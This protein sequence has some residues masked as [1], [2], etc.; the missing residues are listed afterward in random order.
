MATNPITSDSL[1]L[2]FKQL[3][4]IPIGNRVQLA[5]SSSSFL[6]L[7][8]NSLTPIQIAKAFPDYYKRALPDISNFILANRY[9]DAG[10]Q[11]HQTGGGEAGYTSEYYN[12]GNNV[13]GSA[14]PAGSELSIEKMKQKLLEKGIDVEGA[15]SLLNEGPILA[16]DPR[17][18][19]IKNMTNDQLLAAGIQKVEDENGKSMFQL[20]PSKYDNMTD[21]EIMEYAKKTAS[22]E[23]LQPDSKGYVDQDQLFKVLVNRFN[24]SNLNGFVPIDGKAFG[25]E[26]GTPEE[27]ARLALALGKQESSLHA[28]PGGGYRGGMYQFREDDLKRYGVT[29]DV[30]DPNVQVEA[31]AR[32]F[33]KFIPKSGAIAGRG[34]GPGTYGGYRGGAAYFEPLRYPDQLSKHWNS[35]N[36][37]FE[38]YKENPL[39][40]TA[41]EDPNEVKIRLKELEKQ[42]F[43][44][45]LVKQSYMQASP[46][47]SDFKVSNAE[48]VIRSDGSTLGPDARQA[49]RQQ[50]GITI[51]LDNNAGATERDT[52]AFNPMIV[53]PDDATDQ[54]RAAATEYVNRIADAYNKKFGTNL[55]GIV[56]SRSE[57]R[58]GRS[59]TI[60]TEAFNIRDKDA[61]DYFYNTEEGQAEL[62]NITASTLGQIPGANFQLPHGGLEGKDKGA[63]GPFGSE[64]DL[65]SKL[66]A[67]LSR[68]QEEAKNKNTAPPAVADNSLVKSDEEK[69]LLENKKQ[70][71]VEAVPVDNLKKEQ[72]TAKK[73][74]E[75]KVASATNNPTPQFALGGN[76]YGLN[77]DMTLVETETGKPIAQ[78]GQN[79]KIEKQGN[80][81]QVTP[82]TKL[83]ADEL[84]EKYDTSSDVET[85]MNDMEDRIDQQ[86]AVSQVNR[87][88]I[89]PDRVDTS[90][91]NHWREA[92]KEADRP[93][94]PSFHRAI[95]RSKFFPEG[96]HFNRSSPGSIS[97]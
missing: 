61:I 3:M 49:L 13:N 19:F 79:E 72:E 11:A 75:Q 9:F 26:K 70:E 6:Q 29:G 74:E 28:K 81:I 50:G 1:T 55:K 86:E 24:N 46:T 69:T 31:M 15:Y 40:F 10:G 71:S 56:S 63:S 18:Q 37:T 4:R 68:I 77:E 8:V 17:L 76:M 88:P 92:I 41:T 36:T 59:N 67:N 82:E 7:L 60:H 45:E 43:S 57:N 16:G 35:V 53:I 89:A 93:V 94:S 96:H 34:D 30:F 2:D 80:A 90:P 62:A 95:A 97:K 58:R 52:S 20:A 48:Y 83:K 47:S 85:R 39:L 22:V 65:A 42:Q 51:N 64:V 27:W 44:N 21:E 38:S 23:K 25:V 14:T 54:Q 84:A 66:M 78:I 12:Q 73:P 5:M 33:E 91:S 87:K 32:Q